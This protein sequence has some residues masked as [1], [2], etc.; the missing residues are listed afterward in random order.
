MGGAIQNHPSG[1]QTPEIQDGFGTTEAVPFQSTIFETRSS[2]SLTGRCGPCG[3]SRRM[4]LRQ[5]DT[6]FHGARIFYSGNNVG[7]VT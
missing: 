3:M 4:R 5:A 2:L 1:V 7:R 6:F